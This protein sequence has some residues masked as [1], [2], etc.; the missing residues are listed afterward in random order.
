MVAVTVAAVMHFFVP[1]LIVDKARS[2]KQIVTNIIH[3]LCTVSGSN[4]QDGPMSSAGNASSPRT[5][6]SNVDHMMRAFSAAD[7]FFVS[8]HVA[9]AFPELLESRI[10]LAYKSLFLSVEQMS[11]INPNLAKAQESQQPLS[12]HKHRRTRTNSQFIDGTARPLSGLK[13][14]LAAVSLW[15]TTL[16][17]VFGSQSLLGQEFLINMFNPGLVAA[18]AYLGLAIWN[19]SYFGMLVA[20]FLVVG[21]FS[22]VYWAM[23]RVLQRRSKA[24]DWLLQQSDGIV[25]RQK[26]LRSV[27]PITTPVRVTDNNV[28]EAPAIP[29]HE[30]RHQGADG[31][32]LSQPPHPVCHRS[33]FILGSGWG[34]G[35]SG[36]VD[37]GGFLAELG[38]M[39]PHLLQREAWH[40]DGDHE[41]EGSDHHIDDISDD[42]SGNCGG[43]GSDENG[44]FSEYNSDVDSSYHSECEDKHSDGRESDGD[45]E[46]HSGEDQYGSEEV[47]DDSI[48]ID[49]DAIELAANSP[50][51]PNQKSELVG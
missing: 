50:F 42:E 48:V 49:A 4:M 40:H 27:L 19:N 51:G 10:V 38:A 22:V 41:L 5:A 47:G 21:G 32:A 24:K 6:S 33:A 17:L 34:A 37:D 18:I 12:H 7:Y 1:N 28:D 13:K 23:H 15:T 9:R 16:L 3:D 14:M 35:S 45:K 46:A 29:L 11:M 2:I 20:V 44:S 26:S 39:L 43:G 25:S 31:E 8:A 36:L 30:N